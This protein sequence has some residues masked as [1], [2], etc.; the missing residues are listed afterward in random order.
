MAIIEFL[1]WWR[2]QLLELIPSS[3]FKVWQP[4]RSTVSV[5][6]DRQT[7]TVADSTGEVIGEIETRT[8]SSDPDAWHFEPPTVQLPGSPQRL[9]VVLEP[10]QYL[11]QQVSLPRAARPHL[12]EAVS[13]Q[14]PKLTPFSLDQVVYACGVVPGGSAEGPL[15]VWVA[16]VPKDRLAPVLARIGQ[17]MPDSPLS[18][19]HR[20]EANGPLELSWKI[21]A[22]GSQSSRRLATLGWVMVFLV[23]MGALGLHLNDRNDAQL[24]LDRQ[25]AGLRAEAATAGGMR[26]QISKAT[27]SL[28]WLKQRRDAAPSTLVLVDSLTQLLDDQTHL[29]RLDFDGETVRLTGVSK[30]ASNM[31]EALESSSVFQ[32]VR[33]DAFTRDRR[34]QADRFNINAKLENAPAEDAS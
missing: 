25:I 28:E 16:V 14:L 12:A 30:T 27:A 23:W 7:A 2:D 13:F 10:G 5:R 8:L 11:L 6:I 17:S 21:A 31:I 19:H 20:P 33:I 4:V 22:A 29:Q 9:R 32:D 26:E 34:N 15:P 24:H 1:Q 3:L 18:V